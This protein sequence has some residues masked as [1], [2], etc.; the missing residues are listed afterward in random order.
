MLRWPP[1]WEVSEI[2][3]GCCGMAGAFGFEA[4]HYEFSLAVGR[5]RLFPAI[6]ALPPE[7]WVVAPGTSCRQQIEHATGRRVLHPIE[8]LRAGLEIGEGAPE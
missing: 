4:E 3:S 1:Q 8:A 2:D 7:A 5:Q 6:E